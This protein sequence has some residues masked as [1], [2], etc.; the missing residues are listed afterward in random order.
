MRKFS[1]SHLK[2]KKL[3]LIVGGQK[4][5]TTS[6]FDYLSAHPEIYGSNR[7]QTFY[8]MPEAFQKANKKEVPVGYSKDPEEFLKLFPGYLGDEEYLLEATPDYLHTYQA[9]E[10]INEFR[11]VF[12]KVIILIILRDPVERFKSWFNFAKQQNSIERS[13]T[14]KKFYEMNRPVES[15]YNSFD[16]C[17]FALHTGMYEEFIPYYNNFFGDDVKVYSFEAMKSSPNRFMEKVSKDIGVEAD[18]YDDYKFSPSNVTVSSRSTFIR[19]VYM[20]VRSIYLSIFNE[21]LRYYL[22]PLSK[23]VS[24]L[25]HKINDRKIEREVCVEQDRETLEKIKEIYSRTYDY[26]NSS[27]GL[28]WRDR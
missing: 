3:L 2:K 9:L 28:F 10:R 22:C 12:E 4:C 8:F 1:L 11:E 15:E 16:S 20:E 25:Y 14:I 13:T 19:A 18:F 24:K 27:Y 6:L 26:C 17:F 7:K 21:K 23:M 5:G